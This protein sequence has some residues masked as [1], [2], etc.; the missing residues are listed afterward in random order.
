MRVNTGRNHD[1]VLQITVDDRMVLNASNR[2][3]TNEGP[4]QALREGKGLGE[5]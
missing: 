4:G 2:A 5:A 3:Y 1:G